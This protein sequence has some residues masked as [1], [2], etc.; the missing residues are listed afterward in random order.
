MTSRATEIN[1]DQS[2]NQVTLVIDET[3]RDSA[4]PTKKLKTEEV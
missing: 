1:T 4:P 3:N 2:E